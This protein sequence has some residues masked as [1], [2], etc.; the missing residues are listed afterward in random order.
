MDA[1][2]HTL[3]VELV[4]QFLEDLA[5]LEQALDDQSRKLD[6][7]RIVFMT[8]QKVEEHAEDRCLVAV[9]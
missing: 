9:F 5:E 1:N 8:A 7:H 3:N 2:K 4:Y 6:L